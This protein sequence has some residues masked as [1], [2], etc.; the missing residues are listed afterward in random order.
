MLLGCDT[1]LQVCADDV[2]DAFEE[3][4]TTIDTLQTP[5]HV[6][7]ARAYKLLARLA[8]AVARVGSQLSL[9]V[10]VAGYAVKGSGE[11]WES[12]ICVCWPQLI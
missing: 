7:H 2:M 1:L 10:P 5:A 8:G 4:G 12:V 3:A 6:V 9:S 11:E